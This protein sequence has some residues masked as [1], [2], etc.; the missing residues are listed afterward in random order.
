MGSIGD[1]IRSRRKELK[2][3]QADLGKKIGITGAAV[4]QLEIG[5]SK[6]VKGE[7][8]LAFAKALKCN[9]VWLVSGKEESAATSLL[10]GPEIKGVYPLISWVQ[11]GAWPTVYKEEDLSNLQHYPCP[12]ECSDMTFVI[13]VRGMSMTPPFYEGEL[14][15]VDPEAKVESSK[16]VLALQENVVEPV[17]KQVVIE[18][19]KKY[20]RSTNPNWPEP[21]ILLDDSWLIIGVVIFV[22]RTV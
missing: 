21:V 13:H 1:R 20:L 9:P 4:S 10:P 11:A 8:L 3:T 22:G 2:I 15:F 7:H 14:L 5:D 12:V 6:S 17:F 16:Y 19:D 18:G